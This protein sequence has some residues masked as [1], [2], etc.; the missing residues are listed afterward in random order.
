MS[1]SIVSEI[2]GA[3]T[4][5]ILTK[6]LAP[7][8]AFATD[9]GDGISESGGTVVVAG[10]NPASTTGATFAGSYA[11]G[12]DSD[13]DKISVSLTHYF[14]SFYLTDAEVTNSSANRLVNLVAS[15][16]NA[17]GGFLMSELTKV[18]TSSNYGSETSTTLDSAYAVSTVKDLKS[19]LDANGCPLT[20]RALVL[21][22]G[23]L[24]NILPTSIVEHGSETLAEGTINR[25]YGCDTFGTNALDTTNNVNGFMAHKSAIAI[26]SR[27]PQVQ[28]SASLIDY[29][30]FEIPNLGLNI[31]YK[32]FTDNVT[33]R[34]YGVLET[35]AGVAK[36]NADGLVY[37]ISS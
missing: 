20:D 25:I 16:S 26:A 7:F 29:A 34:T 17:F 9:C 30:K 18:I 33:N 15:A 4:I 36:G 27:L 24:G 31:A 23:A 21:S 19:A 2:V 37:T 1:N 14:K 10:V 22:G 5:D 28:D 13:V 35:L 6:Q 3:T 8:S 12:A 11:T 32:S